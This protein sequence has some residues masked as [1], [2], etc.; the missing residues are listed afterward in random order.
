MIFSLVV[1]FGWFFVGATCSPWVRNRAQWFIVDL[2]YCVVCL[3][4]GAMFYGFK[5]WL[6]C[7]LFAEKSFL[8]RV[9]VAVVGGLVAL[10]LPGMILLVRQHLEGS[11]LQFGRLVLVRPPVAELCLLIAVAI[12]EEVVFRGV[13]IYALTADGLGGYQS[14]MV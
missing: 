6:S 7:P 14:T 8:E 11:P 5:M 3:L 13:L 2:F 4:V 12:A 1:T 10:T 9:V